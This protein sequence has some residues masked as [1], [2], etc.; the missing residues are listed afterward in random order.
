[1]PQATKVV[2]LSDTSDFDSDQAAIW[3]E[4]KA[5][6]AAFLIGDRSRIDHRISPDATIWDGETETI[7][8]GL[9]DLNAIRAT[10]PVGEAAAVTSSLKVD[11]PVVTI[12]GDVAIGRHVLRTSHEGASTDSL[13]LRVSSAWKRVGGEWWIIH[14]H[15]DIF[16][17]SA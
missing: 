3:A 12:H 2:D 10:R 7:A 15:E 14:S 9:D 16:S 17:I 8:R 1:M 4:Q 5:I 13:V 11:S 6:Y